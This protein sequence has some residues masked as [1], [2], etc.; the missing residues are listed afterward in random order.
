MLVETAEPKIIVAVR[1]RPLNKKELAKGDSDIV[2]VSNQQASVV[3]R[4]TRYSVVPI[5]LGPKS[6]SPN[7]S[8]STLSSSTLPSTKTLPTNSSIFRLCVPSSK[9]LS[10][11][12]KSPASPT[13]K[14]APEKH[15]PC[16]AITRTESPASTCSPPTI[17][18]ASSRMYAFPNVGPILPPADLHFLLRNL[19]R[20]AL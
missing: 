12:Q 4:E 1:K 13:A 11:G 10:T 19:L 7:T 15:T 20:E 17:F 14:L 18:F 5:L 16:S 9:P 6:I 3:V 2:E 8:K